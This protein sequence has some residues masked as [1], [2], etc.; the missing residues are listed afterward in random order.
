MAN[1]ILA[2]H[3]RS[4]VTR[5]FMTP[6]DSPKEVRFNRKIDEFIFMEMEKH[7]SIPAHAIITDEAGNKLG[8]TFGTELAALAALT[9]LDQID[10][11]DDLSKKSTL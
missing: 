10:T 5:Y 3:E 8:A 6:P 9:A 4:G 11:F 7:P 2:G 1:R